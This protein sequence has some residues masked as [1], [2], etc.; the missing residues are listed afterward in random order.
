MEFIDLTGQKFG[1]LSVIDR[2]P[3]HGRRT[4]WNCVC[5]CGNRIVVRSENLR[6]GNSKSCG[7]LSRD[8]HPRTANGL[9]KTRLA[10]VF[11]GVK[12]RCY[13]NNSKEYYLYGAR[14]ITVCDEWINDSNNFYSWALNNGFKE[15]ATQAEC[16]LDRI[17][18]NGNYC[19]ENCRWVDSYV[20]ANNTRRNIY[21]EYNGE[22]HTLTEWSRIVGIKSSTLYNRINKLGWSLEEALTLPTSPISQRESIKK[23]QAVT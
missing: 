21:Y 12:Q 1:R 9:G 2:A 11:N 4:M 13:N 3:N 22:R 6:S 8:N 16:S 20:Q 10:N 23:Q 17:D 18:V 7:C 15:D 19:P 5:D 14:G